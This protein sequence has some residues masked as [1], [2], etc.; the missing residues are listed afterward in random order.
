MERK[1]TRDN[2]MIRRQEIGGFR[3]HCIDREKKQEI[4]AEGPDDFGCDRIPKGG[5]IY[6]IT[7]RSNHVRGKSLRAM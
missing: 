4:G 6:N 1:Q 7:M 2:E 5:G 3:K